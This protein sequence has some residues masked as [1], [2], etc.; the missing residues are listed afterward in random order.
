MPI[1]LSIASTRRN[2]RRP[3]HRDLPHHSA[4]ATSSYSG[5]PAPVSLGMDGDVLR[6]VISDDERPVK[7]SPTWR[8][9]R[10]WPQEPASV[11]LSS[12]F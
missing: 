10:P 8:E 6:L 3:A 9:V 11:Q 7:S 1:E 5:R 4:L 2:C 12:A